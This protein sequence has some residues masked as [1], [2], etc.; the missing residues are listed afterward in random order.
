MM[1]KARDPANNQR[2]TARPGDIAAGKPIVVLVNAHT[3]A[4]AE[5]VASA[6][7]EHR[8]ATVMGTRSAGIGTIQTI[9]PLRWRNGAL[10]LT[11]PRHSRPSGRTIDGNGVKPDIL[12]EQVAP[13]GNEPPA[14]ATADKSKDAQ[15]QS[16]LS[17]IRQGRR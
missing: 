15:L 6:L 11:T 7:Q 3:A 5:M 10:I 4:G 13:S 1:L 16:A 17:Y 8:R 2:F 14:C 12:V 9:I